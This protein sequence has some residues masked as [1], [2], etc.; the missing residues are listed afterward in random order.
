MLTR[1]SYDADPNAPGTLTGRHENCILE[2]DNRSTNIPTKRG[3]SH[4]PTLQR[5]GSLYD[6]HAK[7]KA[8]SAATSNGIT[9]TRNWI[10][11]EV[12]LP[13]SVVTGLLLPALGWV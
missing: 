13:Q 5:R 12:I 9:K 10:P 3:R 8:A 1:S 7:Y 2:T 4:P 11:A 6:T